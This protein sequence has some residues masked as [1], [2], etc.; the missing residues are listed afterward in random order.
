V[1]GE[2]DGVRVAAGRPSWVEAEGFESSPELDA[3]RDACEARGETT[4]FG[5]WDGRVRGVVSVSDSLRPGA[6]EA[7]SQ[8]LAQGAQVA[9]ISGDARAAAQHA[10]SEAG[11]DDVVA[12]ALPDDKRRML[13]D[14]QARGRRVAFVGDGINDAPAL[15]QADLGMAVASGTEIAAETGDVVLLSGD[16]RAVPQALRLA[17]QTF[18]TISQNLFWAFAYNT[19]AIPAAALGWLDPMIAAGAMAFSSVSVVLNSLR[20]RRFGR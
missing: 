9:M 11:I 20:L 12:E 5:A 8:L 2:V 19:A 3:S 10:A 7:V 17:R 13:A 14:R 16:P 15:A 6:R 18:R 4:F 1:T